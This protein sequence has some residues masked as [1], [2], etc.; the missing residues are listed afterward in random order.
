LAGLAAIWS[1]SSSAPKPLEERA[2][3]MDVVAAIH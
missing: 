2:C 1:R 3:D